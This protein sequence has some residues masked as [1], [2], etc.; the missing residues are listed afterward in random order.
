MKY[1]NREGIQAG[2]DNRVIEALRN[3]YVVQGCEVTVDEDFTL[4]VDSGTIVQD[5]EEYEIDASTVEVSEPDSSPR[6]DVVYVNSQQ[7]LVVASGGDESAQPS[8]EE[9]DDK[10]HTATPS[11]P[12]LRNVDD[13]VVLAE[14]FVED[15]ATSL[16]AE[17][18]L[19]DRRLFV[20]ISA[21][22]SELLDTE[23]IDSPITNDKELTDFEGDNISIENG[24]LNAKSDNETF[25]INEAYPLGE[26]EIDEIRYENELED[27]SVSV[28]NNIEDADVVKEGLG[29]VIEEI[30]ISISSLAGVCLD[31]KDGTL[32]YVTTGGTDIV[33]VD[34][35]ANEIQRI[36]NVLETSD[37]EDL[38][39][40]PFDGTFWVAENNRFELVNIDRDGNELDAIDV[41][42]NASDPDTESVSVD[43]ND[44]TLWYGEGRDDD[45]YHIDRNG[46][47]LDVI[48][49]RDRLEG[50]HVDPRDATIWLCFDDGNGSGNEIQRIDRTGEILEN[51][52]HDNGDPDFKGLGFNH[53]DATLF[54]AERGNNKLTHRATERGWII[55]KDGQ[56][57]VLNRKV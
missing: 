3:N 5:G 47:V 25:S 56:K 22:T 14:V 49:V 4:Q 26:P 20:D 57:H 48:S 54:I 42:D 45:L 11:P 10:F 6:K 32:W 51:Y 43:P 46:N 53:V 55:E 27:S 50:I 18:D 8:L 1:Q 19:R 17:D 12:S 38:T 30:D 16:S 41:S 2:N 44:G 40:D 21:D 23:L 13:P 31:P 34:R 9:V 36:E 15:G 28:T 7:E 39:V 52:E 33:N 35:D 29:E 24:R 37:T